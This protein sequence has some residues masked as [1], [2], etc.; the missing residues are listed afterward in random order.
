MGNYQHNPDDDDDN[1]GWV[2]TGSDGTL[3]ATLSDTNDANYLS[4]PGH[5][6]KAQVTFPIDLDNSAIPDGAVITSITVFLR[7]GKGAGSPPSNTPPSVTVLISALDDRSKFTLRTVYPSSTIAT[8]EVATFSRDVLGNA[9]DLH[10]INQLLAAIFCYVGVADVVRCYRLYVQINYRVRPTITVSAPTGTVNTP[11]PTISWTYRQSDGD[12][13][14]FAEYKIFTAVAQAADSFNA[15]RTPAV[16]YGT[17]NGPTNSVVLPSSLNNDTYYV[18]VRG[19]SSFGAQSKWIGRQFTVAGPAPGT[20]GVDV[21][22]GNPGDSQVQVVANAYAGVAALTMRDTSNMLSVQTAD[23]ETV[24]DASEWG[25]TNCTIGRSVSASYPGSVASW[26][27]TA[28]SAATM[29]VTTGF[30]EVVDTLTITARAQFFAASTLRSCRVDLNFY[31]DNFNLISTT[32]GTA[33]NDSTT[34]WV[35]IVS[36][37]ATTPPLCTKVTATFSVISPA[38]AEVHYLDHAGIM[39][40]T[41]T[42]WSDGGHMSRNLLSSWY[43]N[44]EGTAPSGEGWTGSAAT[45]TGTGN[46]GGTGMSGLLAHKMTYAGISPTLALRAAGT[47]YT[48]TTSGTAFTLNKPAGVL[49]GDLMVAYVLTSVNSTINPPAGWSVVDTASVSDSPND[50]A[51]FVLKRTAG[52]ADPA[53]WTDGTVSLAASRRA[54]VVVAYSGAADASLQFLG[55]AHATTPSNT[56]FLTT[57]SVLNTDANAWRISAFGVDDSASAGTLTANTQPPSSVPPIAFVG[58]AAPWTYA[59]SAST[60]YTIN[61]PPGVI[62][63]DLMVA[64]VSVAGS[65]TV[66]APTGW[67]IAHQASKTNGVEMITTAVLWRSAGGSEPT[68]WSG[69]LSGGTILKSRVSQCTAYRNCSTSQFQVDS[70]TTES[71]EQ[72][73]ETNTITNTNSSAWRICVFAGE[74]HNPGHSWFGGDNVE[75]TDAYASDAGLVASITQ[76]ISDSNQPVSTGSYYERAFFDNGQSFYAGTAWIGMIAPLPAAPTPPANE[77]SRASTSAGASNPFMVLRAFDS[78]GPVAAQA[79]S[80]SGSYSANFASGAGWVGLVKPA[81]PTIYGQ[82]SATMATTVDISKIDPRVITLAGGKVSVAASFLGST[83]GAPLM[84]VNFYRGNALLDVITANGNSFGTGQWVPSSA[85]LDMPAGTTRMNLTFAVGSRAVSDIVYFDRVSLAL[86]SQTVYRTGTSRGAHPVWNVPDIQYAEDTGDGY[87]PW[88]ALPGATS[89]NPA[90]YDPLT[91]LSTFDD[92]SAIPLVNRKYRA[93]TI[94][95]G[96]TGDVFVSPWGPDSLEFSF[97]ALNWWLKD[98]TNADNNLLLRVKYDDVVATTTNTTAAYQPLGADFPVVLTEGFKADTFTLT[99][100]PVNQGDFLKLK[101]LLES[102]RTL[103]LQSDVDKA[104]WV[105]PTSGI[106]ATMLATSARQENPLRAIEVTF[107]EV[108]PEV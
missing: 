73:I 48:A 62:S 72:D 65:T 61:R 43:S 93:R 26:K 68:S 99:L 32:T 70:I 107:T 17:V 35:E 103:F 21:P 63:G 89:S 71:T 11:S 88:K 4:C 8:T 60:T 82:A 108:Q 44:A 10:R 78:N 3:F 67:T 7:H 28:S 59:T 80:V 100:I 87:G 1:D 106:K 75:R 92:H 47:A 34:S 102:N 64:A 90:S 74:A 41:N 42:P 18:Y 66:V 79:W 85:V 37:A 76:S 84:S 38:N 97:V 6:G 95:Y 69:T 58:T 16:F 27:L 12:P 104:W 98:I 2:I 52:G 86:G 91:G 20:P 45:T 49:S 105:R 96:L 55:D 22:G 94:S 56:N 57:P 39:Y 54:A 53:S 30:V 19:T 51:L 23:A 25:T 15:N 24:T 40:G 77:T 50:T 14:T 9:W 5:K 29:S 101:A 81:T 83:A 46:P 36:A 13:Q 33:V 31:D